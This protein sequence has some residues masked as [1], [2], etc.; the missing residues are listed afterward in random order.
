M[1]K[2]LPTVLFARS[3]HRHHARRFRVPLLLDSIKPNTRMVA[4]GIA[5]LVEKVFPNAAQTVCLV[6]PLSLELAPLLKA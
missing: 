1:Q 6:A 4:S 2:W 3:P 5:P